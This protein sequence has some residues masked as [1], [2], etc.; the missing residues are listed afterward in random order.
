MVLLA[1]WSPPIRA[2]RVDDKGAGLRYSIRP[3][4]DLLFPRIGILSAR[5]EAII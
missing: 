4:P 1:T 5:V 2:A 3:P